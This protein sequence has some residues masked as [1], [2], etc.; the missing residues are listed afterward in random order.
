MAAE[1]N[2]KILKESDS[3]TANL[4]TAVVLPG[5][6]RSAMSTAGAALCEL[7]VRDRWPEFIGRFDRSRIGIYAV[8]FDHYQF[9][10]AIYETWN[11]GA[12]IR[13]HLRTKVPPT[14]VLTRAA[15]MNAGC[16]SILLNVTGPIY[17]FSYLK[18]AREDCEIMAEMDFQENRIDLAI[19][20]S[21]VSS[22]NGFDLD[23]KIEEGYSLLAK[24]RPL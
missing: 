5:L 7:A 18:T 16:L 3:Q 14:V 6:N 11:P 19:F 10:P 1:S 13:A 9:D 21:A 22:E 12:N 2:L 23:S 15:G 17:T 4:Q 8:C 24:G 20:A